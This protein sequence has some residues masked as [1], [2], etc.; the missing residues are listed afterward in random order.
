MVWKLKN[1]GRLQRRIF[2]VIFEVC[3]LYHGNT[4]KHETLLNKGTSYFKLENK[5]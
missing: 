4:R 2:V 3:L 1:S 5:Q